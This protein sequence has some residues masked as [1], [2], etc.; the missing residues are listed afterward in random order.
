MEKRSVA[1]TSTPN[2]PLTKLVVS[3][4]RLNT[5]IAQNMSVYRWGVVQSDLTILLDNDTA[6][7]QSKPDSLVT[8]VPGKR[9]YVQIYKRRM[10]VLGE[11]VIQ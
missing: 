1:T 3:I 10:V 5:R 2:N 6:P 7:L 4:A 9:V 11:A 8:L